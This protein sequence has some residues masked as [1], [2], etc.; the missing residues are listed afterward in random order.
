[1]RRL[2][3]VSIRELSRATAEVTERVEA[4]ERL[5]VTRHGRPVATLQPLD[6]YVVQPFTGAAHDV[7]GWA[8]GNIDEEIAKLSEG[9]RVLLRDG[10][11]HWR[12]WMGR[13]P[14]NVEGDRGEML[15]D[16]RVRGL[17]KKTSCGW[18]PTG[19]GLALHEALSGRQP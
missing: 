19:R 13:V 9:Q 10:Y 6:G 2:R 17:A 15:E 3:T 18:E 16:L 11:R 8:I 4:G 5:I 1:M 12:L 14:S 7:F